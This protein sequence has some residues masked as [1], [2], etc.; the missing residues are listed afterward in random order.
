MSVSSVPESAAIAIEADD[1]T[2]GPMTAA[3]E[4]RAGFA[5][6]LRDPDFRRLWC[7][8]VCSGSGGA[9]AAIAM[10]LFVYGLSGSAQAV[11]LVA[12]AQILP[13][14]ILAPFTG[15]LADRLNRRRLMMAADA[16]RLVL[17][18]FLPFTTEIWQTVIL[19]MLIAVGGA[20]GRPAELAAVPLVAGEGRLVTALSLAQVTGGLI[21]VAMPAAG[22]GI[23][24]ALGPGPVFWIQALLFGGSLLALRGLMIPSV[25]GGDASAMTRHD[26]LLRTAWADMGAGIRAVGRV[27]IVRGV[28]AADA[29]T[30]VAFA[31]AVVAGLVYTKETLQLGDRAQ[32]AYAFTATAFFAGAVAGGLLVRRVE[33]RIGR[34]ATLTIGYAGAFFLLP[35]A[36]GAPM[37]V[38]YLS[39]FGFGTLYGFTI[40]AGQASLAEAVPDHERGRV[41]A[42]W[43]AT[44]ALSSALASFGIGWLAQTAGAPT[45]FAVAAVS[46]GVGAP[47]SLRIT[48]AVQALREAGEAPTRV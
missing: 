13:G 46:V 6:L 45:A 3:R 7:S 31:C 21:L 10:P 8:Q 26:G 18:S 38:I 37:P 4:P 43:G 24:A 15:L 22:A 44:I 35:A 1:T 47:L 5:T 40:V 11:G 16:G 34:S 29:F 36:F 17:V 20:I 39:W 19:A 14:V 32:V 23:V 48:G 25:A 27:P 2:P 28:T 9:L 42:A 33:P 41:Y 12:L 30:Q